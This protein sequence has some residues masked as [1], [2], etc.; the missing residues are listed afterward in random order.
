MQLKILSFRLLLLSSLLSSLT[1]IFSHSSAHTHT[2]QSPNV[3]STP[4]PSTRSP[5]VA[6]VRVP[7]APPAAS[8]T[9][10]SPAGVGGAARKRMVQTLEVEALDR[11][12]RVRAERDRTERQLT[13]W[14]QLCFSVVSARMRTRAHTRA[15]TAS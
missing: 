14:R 6:A 11:L 7:P 12:R 10:D 1:L 3:R 9:G 8:P 4:R 5:A 15:C 2:P 13:G